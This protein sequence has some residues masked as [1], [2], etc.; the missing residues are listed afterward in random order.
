MGEFS[1]FLS[2]IR[3]NSC[4]ERYVIRLCKFSDETFPVQVLYLI[5]IDNIFSVEAYRSASQISL[6]NVLRS[7]FQYKLTLFSQ[8]IQIIDQL[9][10]SSCD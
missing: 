7:S 4:Q 1:S 3:F 10:V 9:E 2:N 5:E 6:T 8:L